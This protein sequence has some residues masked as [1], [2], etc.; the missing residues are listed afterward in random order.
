MSGHIRRRV[1]ANGKVRYSPRITIDGR[2]Q[3]LDSFT[4]KKDAETCLRRV[5]RELAAGTYGR[6]N[7]T[8]G[9]F[10][11]RWIKGKGASLKPSTRK[12]YE[13]TFESHIL[14]YLGKKRIG[15]ITPREV[16]TW[17]GELAE[18]ARG[19]AKETK[20]DKEEA[21]YLSPATVAKCYRCLR[22]CLKQAEAWGEI[23]RCPCHSIDLPRSNRE[24]I[25]FLEPGEIGL[26]LDA[27]EEPERTLFATL[28][29]SGLRLGEAL[30]LAWRHVSFND[31]AIL[32]ERSWSRYG[33]FQEPKTQTSRRAVPMMPSFAALLREH[34]QEEGCPAP[35]ALVFSFSGATPL[36]PGNTRRELYR[37][38]DT[39]KLKH[40]SLHSLRHSFASFMLAS[41]ASVKALQR[42]LGHASATMTLNT[43]SHLIQEDLGNALLRADQL[44]TGAGG[45]LVRLDEER[46]K[47]LQGASAS[48]T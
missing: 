47:G 17:I 44:I 41:G 6:E 30:G 25:C 4:L 28:A 48:G 14:P 33:G 11:V 5:Q 36:D 9:A 45:K 43:Y 7:P 32:V 26:L 13:Q 31:N 19:E 27:A 20:K 46:G 29:F 34:Y 16:Q 8:L 12:S 24:E 22:A 1:L 35:D 3:Q 39:A 38:L 15:E 18:K 21:K 42:S 40:V 10:Y 37:A 23:T 2:E